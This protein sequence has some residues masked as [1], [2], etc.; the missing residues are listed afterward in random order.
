MDHA[1][2]WPWDRNCDP[3]KIHP[4]TWKMSSSIF[5]AMSQLKFESVTRAS[6]PS[7][8]SIDITN[9]E[10]FSVACGIAYRSYHSLFYPTKTGALPLDQTCRYPCQRCWVWRQ[11]FHW[12]ICTISSGL[13]HHPLFP[14][15]HSPDVSPSLIS[16]VPGWL[17]SWFVHLLRVRLVDQDIGVR[18]ALFCD[19]R[20]QGFFFWS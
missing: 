18:H 11:L 15:C 8:P 1:W 2:A 4:C 17:G 5:S 10:T 9:G 16:C 3:E 6:P 20:W 7:M 12:S 14:N 13:V 19:V